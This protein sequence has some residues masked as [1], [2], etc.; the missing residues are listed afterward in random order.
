MK[1]DILENITNEAKTEFVQLNIIGTENT[2]IRILQCIGIIC[3]VM[4]HVGCNVFSFG[5][6]LPYASFHIRVL[7]Q[8]D[9]L[10]LFPTDIPPIKDKNYNWKRLSVPAIFYSPCFLLPYR[11]F[12]Q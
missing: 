7:L 2:H 12:Q 10:L 11:E 9:R 3:V 1:K 6:W 4:G 5:N 8:K